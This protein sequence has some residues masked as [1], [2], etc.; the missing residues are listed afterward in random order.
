MFL[1]TTPALVIATLPKIALGVDGIS[2]EVLQEGSGPTPQ[3][4]QTA[5]VD[6]TLW[7]NGFQKKQID[8]SKGLLKGP[9]KF[10]VG[11]G[12]VIPGWDRTVAE[13]RVGE[14]RR[15][16]IDPSLGYGEKGMGPI[17]GNSPLY[18]EIELLE[19]AEM[20]P[21]NAEQMQWL[22]EHPVP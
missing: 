12:Q 20:K 15:V 10:V 1:E 4:T 7:V 21:L 11:V 14:K 13:M 6:Y 3:R 16:V 5:K 2:V 17:P 19:L 8:S 9:F 22:E 18:F